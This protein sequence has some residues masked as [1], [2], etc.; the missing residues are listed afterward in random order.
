G[1]S[2]NNTRV[3]PDPLTLTLLPNPNLQVFSIGNAPPTANAGG[4]VA[5]D[6]TVINQGTVEARGHWTDNVYISLKNTL[7]GTAILLGSFGNQSAL[8]PGAKYT[9]PTSDLLVPKR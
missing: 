4:T 8:M 7:D 6:F 5:L 3:D 9:T 2:G 1:A